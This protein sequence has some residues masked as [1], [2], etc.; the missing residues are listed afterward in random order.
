MG[1]SSL[2]RTNYL[3]I[4]GLQATKLEQVA[5]M[6]AR[7]AAEMKIKLKRERLRKMALRKEWRKQAQ[8]RL[9]AVKVRPAARVYS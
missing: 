9:Y 6:E 8:E 4:S 2:R 5:Q 1:T 7:K 3:N